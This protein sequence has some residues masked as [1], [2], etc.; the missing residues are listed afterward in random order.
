M[1]WFIERCLILSHGKQNLYWVSN[2]CSNKVLLSSVRFFMIYRVI[3]AR[4]PL[5][6]CIDSWS[7]MKDR[8][9]HRPLQLSKHPTQTAKQVCSSWTCES[10]NVATGHNNATQMPLSAR[11]GGSVRV[12]VSILMGWAIKLCH[13]QSH[14]CRCT[15]WYEMWYF[16]DADNARPYLY[17]Y[18][19]SNRYTWTMISQHFIIRLWLFKSKIGGPVRSIKAPMEGRVS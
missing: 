9:I 17:H 7:C 11:E 2:H 15:T 4:H 8:T 16:C 13:Q 12:V 1:I 10:V 18:L 14:F 3:G 19:H 5:H 6:N